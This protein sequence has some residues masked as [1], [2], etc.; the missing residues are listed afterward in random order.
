MNSSGPDQVRNAVDESSLPE[1]MK[2][3][4]LD[5][6]SQWHPRGHHVSYVG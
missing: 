4:V 2:A 6:L 5:R 1:K 3:R